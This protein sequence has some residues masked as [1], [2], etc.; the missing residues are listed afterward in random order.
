MPEIR[1]SGSGLL[2]VASGVGV[3]GVASFP[4]SF[5]PPPRRRMEDQAGSPLEGD[6]D[7][8]QDGGRSRGPAREDPVEGPALAAAA[9]L[10]YRSRWERHEIGRE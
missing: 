2:E 7:P 3:G 5:T 9:D 10:N 4:L 8:F 1:R 6:G